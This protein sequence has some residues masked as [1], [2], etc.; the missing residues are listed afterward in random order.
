M[1]MKIELI[2]T[3]P[4]GA[5]VPRRVSA[6]V[7]LD[8]SP[9]ELGYPASIEGRLFGLT[10]EL[11]DIRF[12]KEKFGQEVMVEADDRQY[13]FEELYPYKDGTFKLRRDW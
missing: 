9:R 5:T 6:E 11:A 3:S 7:N 2:V 4:S 10:E 13:K 12:A 8:Q 1:S